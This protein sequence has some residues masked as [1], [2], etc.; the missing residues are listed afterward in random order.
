[1]LGVGVLSNEVRR[2]GFSDEIRSGTTTRHIRDERYR[3]TFATYVFGVDLAVPLNDRLSLVPDIRA[4]KTFA[5]AR[6]RVFTP[7]VALRWSF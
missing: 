3:Q 1:M 6:G 5:F 7:R 4:Q 2:E